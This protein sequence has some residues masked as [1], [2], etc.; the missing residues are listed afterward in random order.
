VRGGGY[1]CHASYCSR[2]RVYARSANTPDSTGNMGSGWRTPSRL[3][4]HGSG[5]VSTSA[6]ASRRTEG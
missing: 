3:T 2:Y 4:D 6:S 1:L 5:R